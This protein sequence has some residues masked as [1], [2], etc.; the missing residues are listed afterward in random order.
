MA[1]FHSLRAKAL[2]L[3]EAHPSAVGRGYALLAGLSNALLAI[4]MKFVSKGVP[5][6]YTVTVQAATAITAVVAF[7]GAARGESPYP[8]DKQLDLALFLRGLMGSGLFMGFNLGLIL[9]PAPNFMVIN[10]TTSIWV[11]LL[12]PFF[13]NEYP[14]AT[15]L[16]MV[17]LS[18]LG[19]VLLVDPS[20]VLPA[21]LL[22]DKLQAAPE[23]RI[24]LYYY[25]LPLSTGIGG[26]GVNIFLKAFASRIT[27]FNNAFYFLIFCAFYGGLLRATLPSQYAGTKPTGADLML[28]AVTGVCGICFQIFLSLAT[29]FE[30]RASIVSV[31]L[32]SQVVFTFLMDFL[33]LGNPVDGINCLGAVIVIFCAVVITFSKEAASK[34]DATEDSKP[35]AEMRSSDALHDKKR[36]A[37]E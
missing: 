34:K 19:I 11:V 12:A 32:N 23:T 15:I 6:T 35:A 17:L 3:H 14:N 25:L 4:L 18:F 28:M 2:H 10:N 37:D 7:Y 31:L 29:K 8:G 26:A 13:L 36:L 9:L 16:S 21:S 33:V 20:F 27:V 5:F 22:P 30:H 1:L 24:P